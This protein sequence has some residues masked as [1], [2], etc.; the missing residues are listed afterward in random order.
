MQLGLTQD[1]SRSFLDF[2][3]SAEAEA[4]GALS[5]RQDIRLLPHVFDVGIHEY[6][7]LAH[8]GWIAP[9]EVDHFLC[10]YSSAKFAPVIEDLLAKAS[11]S[12]PSD[13]WYSNLATRGNTGAASIFV[14]LAEWF[15]TRSPKA[16]DTVLCFIPESGRMTAAFMCFEVVP[17][18]GSDHAAAP[19]P[20]PAPRPETAASPESTPAL[21]PETFTAPHDPES[22]G[23]ALRPVLTAL[24]GIWQD[25]RSR[26][27]RAPVMQQLVHGR[28]DTAAYR[29]WTSNWVPQVREGSKWMREGV[30]S[31][32]SRFAALASLIGLHAGEEQDDFKILYEDYRAAG[33]ELPLDQLRRN[34]GG[35][36]LNAYLHG[37]AST[38]NPLGLLGA[39]Y[40]IEGTGQRIV[41]SL[42]PL[43][44]E[45]VDLP[46][47][48]FRFLAYHGANDE[49]HL[50]RWLQ[51]IQIV[52]ALEP[53]A[54]SQI[55]QTAR[56]TAQL[57]ALQFESI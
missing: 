35:E 39:I 28:F 6:V 25:Y 52:L 10:H 53:A 9:G 54:A 30:A 5:L 13:R 37:L 2:A 1:R 11:L 48:A 26:V 34:P 40:I 4:A 46:A 57:Y 50:A 23:D 36:A 29:H 56:H 32:D 55:V 7:K 45:Q 49:H 14:M 24:A 51:A 47:S 21:H 31:L 12:V 19:R 22:G 17:V 44:R 33:G 20:A 27:W 41:P 8:D 38:P 18:S 15:A 43:L 16:G 3:T 42:M